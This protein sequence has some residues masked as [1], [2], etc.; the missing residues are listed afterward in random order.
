M[1][2]DKQIRDLNTLDLEITR[3]ERCSL[4]VNGMCIPYWTPFTKYAIIG[5]APGIREIA[6]NEPFVGKSGEIL[7]GNNGRIWFQEEGVSYYKLNK[8]YTSKG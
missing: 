1:L 4:H 5:E 2:S 8:L 7:M 6:N 3:C